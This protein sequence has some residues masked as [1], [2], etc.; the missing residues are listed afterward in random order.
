MSKLKELVEMASF[1]S[2]R[3]RKNLSEVELEGESTI[4]LEQDEPAELSASSS[5]VS[6]SKTNGIDLRDSEPGEL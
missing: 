6:V 5:D 2:G 1:L 4:D 3:P